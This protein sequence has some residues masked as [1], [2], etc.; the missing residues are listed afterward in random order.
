[1]KKISYLILLLLV[2]SIGLSSYTG[3]EQKDNI[4]E[5]NIDA[6]LFDP[7]AYTGPY[8]DVDAR[9]TTVNG[10]T[11]EYEGQLYSCTALVLTYKS[12][13]ER[14]GKLYCLEGAV[15]VTDLYDCFRIY[16]V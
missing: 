6:L 16:I 15:Y 3:H 11:I 10:Y 2:S 13:G 7:Q 5:Q 4:I 14:G 1:M 9:I 8:K 12:C